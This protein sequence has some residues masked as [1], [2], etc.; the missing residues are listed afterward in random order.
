MFC[1]SY[2]EQRNDS[3]FQLGGKGLRG[4]MASLTFKN[5]TL[6]SIYIY[7]YIFYFFL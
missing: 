4:V 5:R 6:P 3:C 2:G 1:Y 7:I